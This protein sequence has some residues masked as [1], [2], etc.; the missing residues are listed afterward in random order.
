MANPSIP[1]T[2]QEGVVS[3]VPLESTCGRE[4]G[5]LQE[6]THGNFKATFIDALERCVA[7]LKISMS[8]AQDTS[9]VWKKGLMVSK[10]GMPTL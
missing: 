6:K 2:S 3:V 8:T 7:V 5:R 10:A 4:E 9:K 1:S